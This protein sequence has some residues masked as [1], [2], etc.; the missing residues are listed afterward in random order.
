MAF[1]FHTLVSILK[2]LGS[3]LL[4]QRLSPLATNPPGELDVLGHDGD[5]LGMDGA[6]VGVLK[7]VREVSLAGLLQKKH[8][9]GLLRYPLHNKHTC[10]CVCAW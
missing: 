8:I 3:V 1:L 10:A 5:T 7:Q 2:V 4:Y 9:L 6:E